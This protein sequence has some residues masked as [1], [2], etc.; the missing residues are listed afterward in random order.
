M[1]GC[2]QLH[3]HTM[4]TNTS[5][6]NFPP[7]LAGDIAHYI[8]KSVRRPVNSFAI[9]G[10]LSTLACLNRNRAYVKPSNT[11]LNLYACL[12]SANDDEKDHTRHAVSHLLHESG[13]PI[14]EKFAS[15]IALLRTLETD[16]EAFL[17][18]AGFDAH[19]QN[20]LSRR[21]SDA[22]KDFIRELV[23]LSDLGRSYYTGKVF[24]SDRPRIGRINQP[25]VNLLATANPLVLRGR[26]TAESADNNLFNCTLFVPVS[27]E[28]PVNRAPDSTISKA[29][30]KR[31]TEA[32]AA[33]YPGNW[34][35]EYEP[36]GARIAG[37]FSQW[38]AQVWAVSQFVGNCRKSSN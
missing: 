27:E 35:L 8:F 11:P 29:L 37:S 30:D 38:G 23:L 9:A 1:P 18:L 24:A 16:K 10:A 32:M 7:G 28:N 12:T 5:P 25:Y 2:W 3:E 36:G 34:A 22:Q 20:A 26:I 13:V 6:I 33:V 14:P 19:L 17:M 31:L 15:T 4:K 21:G